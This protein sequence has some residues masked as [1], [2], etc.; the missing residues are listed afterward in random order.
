MLPATTVSSKKL[1]QHAP[2]GAGN[3]G[4]LADDTLEDAERA[5]LGG[6][7]HE[8]TAINGLG[9]EVK[10]FRSHASQ[11]TFAAMNR[12]HAEGKPIDLITL[13]DT[14][15]QD[16]PDLGGYDYFQTLYESVSTAGN[17]KYYA[18]IVRDHWK[19]RRLFQAATLISGWAKDPVDDVSQ[20]IDM[21][22]EEVEAIRA[23]GTP[24]NQFPKPIPAPELSGSQAAVP[25]IWEKVLAHGHITLFTALWKSG[26]TQMLSCLLPCLGRDIGKFCGLDTYQTRVLLCSEEPESIWASRRDAL[27]I[28]GH[29]EL[30]IRPFNAKP[31]PEEWTQFVG[32]IA[33]LVHDENFGLVIFDPL[34]GLWPVS[35]ENDSA[36][37][38]AALMP[39][40]KITEAGAGL[41]LV[42][43]PRKS[44]GQEGTSARGSGALAAFADILIELRRFTPDS[45]EDRRRVLRGYARVETIGE[46]VVELDASGGSYLVHGSKK[47]AAQ[48]ETAEE[49]QDAMPTDES[50]AMTIDEI[51]QNWPGEDAPAKKTLKNALPKGVNK[52]L[53]NR[54]GDGTRKSPYRYWKPK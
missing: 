9:L 37:V 11:I 32:Y 49:I 35:N 16:V 33:G 23:D 4:D 50:A 44:D 40:R 18:Q 28:Q 19:R 12:L 25:W 52:G 47:E 2:S 17:I 45:M 27:G 51:I 48:K 53:W 3:N 41:C 15:R 24:Q 43:H 30:M 46:M 20:M 5:V 26:K 29:A 31:T 6:I 42:H 54:K 10:H 22:V 21:A 7:L 1:I 14:L 13:A 39:L 8:P 34:S 36:E 38:Q